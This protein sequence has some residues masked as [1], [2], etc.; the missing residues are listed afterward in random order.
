MREHQTGVPGEVLGLYGISI[1]RDFYASVGHLSYVGVDVVEWIDIGAHGIVP[2]E[3]PG[4]LVVE[5]D[6]TVDASPKEGIVDTHVEHA[7]RFPFQVLVGILS[8]SQRIVF[9]GGAIGV[10]EGELAT[11]T[12]GGHGTVGTEPQG[13]TAH[14]VAGTQ[15]QV[16]D[17]IIVLQPLFLGQVPCCTD[18]GEGAPAVVRAEYGRTVATQ[19]SL[20]H[21]LAVVGVVHASVEGDVLHCFLGAALNTI[22]AVYRTGI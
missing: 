2:D 22:H 6:A 16:A 4:L 19:C 18:R 8:G 9:R 7:G 13:I 17:D 12:I 15:F 11:G 1:D 10:D 14:A 20:D 21:V 5:L 3:V